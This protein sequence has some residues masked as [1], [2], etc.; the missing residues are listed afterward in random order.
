LKPLYVF[1]TFVGSCLLGGG[2]FAQQ[3]TISGTVYDN[4]QRIPLQNVSVLSHKGRGTYTDSTGHYTLSVAPDDSL[5]F[6]YN[7]KAT[8]KYLVK[9]I[10]YPYAFD[11]SLKVTMKNVLP[12]V[13]VRARSYRQDSLENRED[14]AKVF[15]YQKPNPLNTINV[16]GAAVGVDPNSIIDMFR[17]KHNRRIQALQTRLVQ[18]EQDKYVNYRFNK[19]LVKKLT[20][21]QG[22]ALDTFMVRYRPNYAFVQACN[23]LELYQYIWLAGKQFSAFLARKPGEN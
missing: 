10:T 19:P 21:L 2:A 23:D 20:G 17:F 14:Y 11:M 9:D 15:N 3:L 16:G 5:Y 18:Q 12:N 4:S 6:A 8:K 13:T 1:L 22:A 7:G